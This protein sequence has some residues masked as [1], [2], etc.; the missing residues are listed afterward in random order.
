MKK[1]TFWIGRTSKDNWEFIRSD[2]QPVFD[3]QDQEFRKHPTAKW[4]FEVIPATRFKARLFGAEKLRVGWAIQ[5][6]V[7][8]SEPF[9]AET[10]GE[11][12][13]ATKK[14]MTRRRRSASEQ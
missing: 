3:R 11:A 9:M 7:D 8:S 5:L 12:K 6:R 10:L 1:T 13:R 14:S 2:T 4:L